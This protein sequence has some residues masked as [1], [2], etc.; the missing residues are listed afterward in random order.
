VQKNGIEFFAFD[1]ENTT[2]KENQND[3]NNCDY[4]NNNHNHNS[5]N[6][7]QNDNRITTRIDII[8]FFF[9]NFIGRSLP[10]FF[11]FLTKQKKKVFEIKKN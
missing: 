8:F 4:N 5:D 2:D 9:S 1:D 11:L 6:N 3:K 7:H 10:K